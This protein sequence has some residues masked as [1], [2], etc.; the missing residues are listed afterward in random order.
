MRKITI[1]TGSDSGSTAD[2]RPAMGLSRVPVRDGIPRSQL[3]PVMWPLQR[4]RVCMVSQR[5]LSRVLARCCG[6]EFEDV[7][8]AM[9]DVDLL[10]PAHKRTS[11]FRMRVRNALSRHTSA[12]RMVSSG[13]HA[14][15]T[16]PTYDLFFAL[17]QFPGDLLCLDAVPRWRRRCG[18]AVCFIEEIWSADID[19]LGPQ[20]NVLKKFDYVFSGCVGTVERLS[21][22]LQR[23]VGYLSP[24]VDAIRFAPH[25]RV[26]KRG[27]DVCAIGRNSPDTHA[28]LLAHANATGAFYMYESLDGIR[29]AKV[30]H[31]HRLLLSSLIKN[32]R[33]FLVRKAKF[34]R[35]F[36]T[37]G[38]E[39]IGFRY[40]EGA[41]GGAVLIGDRP[42]S[43][44]FDELLGWEDSVIPVELDAP[45]L[46]EIIAALDADPA[47]LAGIHRRNVV[48]SLRR[49]DWLYR[50]AAILEAAGLPPGPRMARRQADIAVLA[51][52][53]EEPGAQP[54]RL[55]VVSKEAARA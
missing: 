41:A 28:T 23:P 5:G 15:P 6:Y 17:V 14:E 31:E 18:F 13:L 3:G 35:D 7:I 8:T 45:D 34:N 47:R 36:E 19:R 20:L 52:R 9:D 37:A 12:Y 54:D 25:P 21:E 1:G 30:P 24:G 32:S 40:F 2:Q 10:V 29:S 55:D 38:Q 22:H 51:S 33:Y 43:E 4:P 11:R 48:N 44:K 27:I 46:P 49:H 16:Q 42:Q 53:F 26:E 39:E 50:W